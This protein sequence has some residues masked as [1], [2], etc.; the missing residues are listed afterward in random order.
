MEL[1]ALQ[2]SRDFYELSTVLLLVSLLASVV[3]HLFC[4]CAVGRR[5]TKPD[6][7]PSMYGGGPLPG[8][9]QQG[10]FQQLPPG[11][12]PNHGVPP[13]EPD[14]EVEMT[15]QGANRA[16]HSEYQEI[17]DVAGPY[18]PVEDP[19]L[20]LQ[21][22]QRQQQG[23]RQEAKPGLVL[24]HETSP[25]NRAKTLAQQYNEYA[26]MDAYGGD[27]PRDPKETRER[28]WAAAKS[29][30]SLSEATTAVLPGGGG[31]SGGRVRT[32]EEEAF[33]ETS[34]DE[35]D[36]M[37]RLLQDKESTRRSSGGHSSGGGGHRAGST[38]ASG[39]GRGSS[40]RTGG[41]KPA[42]STQGVRGEGSDDED[43]GIG[44]PPVAARKGLV[45]KTKNKKGTK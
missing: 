43:V 29:A 4:F 12:E 34:S 40:A 27:A 25:N 15:P 17:G 6:A 2:K 18:A 41:V 45:S 11:Y 5:G 13:N 14:P 10:N 38:P 7:T 30:R 35:A 33:Y 9:A 31:G 39:V 28:E 36:D 22:V 3:L 20:H 21:Q 1:T 42:A 44:A 23:H 19:R 26:Y 37:S 16:Q 32:M 24:Q 8:H